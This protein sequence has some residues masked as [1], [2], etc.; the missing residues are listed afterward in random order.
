MAVEDVARAIMQVQPHLLEFR[1]PRSR[2]SPNFFAPAN[3]SETCTRYVVID[4]VL[5][6]LGWDL[7]DPSCCR[8]E[9]WTKGGY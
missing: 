9:Y 1:R 4:P 6:S 2:K 8:V 5:R 7:S 3:L